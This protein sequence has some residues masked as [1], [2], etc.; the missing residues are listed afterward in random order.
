MLCSEIITQ[1]EKT[2][3]KDARLDLIMWD[4]LQDAGKKK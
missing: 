3:P 2:Y 4:Y 1:I